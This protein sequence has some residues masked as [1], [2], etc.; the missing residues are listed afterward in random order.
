[1]AEKD[2]GTGV[3]GMKL[4]DSAKMPDGQFLSWQPGKIASFQPDDMAWRLEPHSDLVIQM[5]MRPSGKPE[6]IQPSVGFYF[7]ETPP[8]KNPIKI[9]LTSLTIDIP[10]DRD[11]YTVTDSFV[12][13]V[14]VEVTAAS[15]LSPFGKGWSTRRNRISEMHFDLTP[16]IRPQEILWTRS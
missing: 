1:M 11:D 6:R 15:A 3:T 13:P 9:V 14:D 16:T 2:A 12:F 5:H 4:A 7:T 10:S 8:S